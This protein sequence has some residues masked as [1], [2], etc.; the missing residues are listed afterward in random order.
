M[1]EID[2]K[3]IFVHSRKIGPILIMFWV[4]ND[5]I[6]QKIMKTL[7]SFETTNKECVTKLLQWDS[8][9]S[10]YKPPININAHTVIYMQKGRNIGSIQNPDN[11]ILE[12]FYTK[13]KEINFARLLDNREILSISPLSEEE[14]FK[15]DIKL[16]LPGVAVYQFMREPTN[17]SER[18][19]CLSDKKSLPSLTN[20]PN[21]NQKSFKNRISN[22]FKGKSPATKAICTQ[23]SN[24]KNIFDGIPGVS[25][26]LIKNK[27]HF[28]LNKELASESISLPDIEITEKKIINKRKT[29]TKTDKVKNIT[30]LKIGEINLLK[31]PNLSQGKRI[32][33]TKIWY[34]EIQSNIYNIKS[35]RN[36]VIETIE[37][38][39]KCNSTTVKNKNKIHKQ[40]LKRKPSLR[41]SKKLKLQTSNSVKPISDKIQKKIILEDA[42]KSQ[43]TKSSPCV[44]YLKNFRV[45]KD[46][47]PKAVKLLPSL[48]QNKIK[49]ICDQNKIQS[50]VDIKVKQNII[51][52][53]NLKR[54][55]RKSN[56]LNNKSTKF[57]SNKTEYMPP[58]LDSTQNN[59]IINPMSFPYSEKLHDIH[60]SDANQTVGSKEL[61]LQQKIS[62]N[63]QKTSFIAGD[64][65]NQGLHQE[66][67]FPGISSHYHQ[68]NNCETKL[69]Q[70]H[71][72][73][74]PQSTVPNFTN[75][76]GY[77]TQGYSNQQFH[78]QN[79]KTIPRVRTPQTYN[80]LNNYQPNQV[81]GNTYYQLSPTCMENYMSD[82]QGFLEL[83][84]L[85]YTDLNILPQYSD[86]N[87]PPS[88]VN[89]EKT[90]S[91]LR[92]MYDL[93]LPDQFENTH[94]NEQ[95]SDYSQNNTFY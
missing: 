38:D 39:K 76:P 9:V 25:S 87:R 5:E 14:I 67:N 19:K 70:V 45:T 72:L 61:S 73:M 17:I 85:P 91:A 95:K 41:K 88:F 24:R 46:K 52:L 66:Q 3:H 20:I 62:P 36:S 11:N 28:I 80:I 79:V 6:C 2:P 57:D 32:K 4:E 10:L 78:N 59:V 64:K 23:N 30:D 8:V 53:E 94:Y 16:N 33:T 65:F 26:L 13:C 74:D 48:H 7:L 69:T 21:C 40:N 42:K 15:Y 1:I 44:K 89:Q 55:S 58:L 93:Y 63:R 82:N 90:D 54:K 47:M 22:S 68:T 51:P 35:N 92:E 37:K 81:S 77:N 34:P 31:P 50:E 71:K 27:Q 29:S 43:K 86:L 12:K 75:V 60:K 18:Y 83:L 49:N 56:Q 84:N